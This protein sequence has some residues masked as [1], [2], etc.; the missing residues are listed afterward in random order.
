MVIYL[1]RGADLHMSQLMPLPLTVSVK[2]RLVLPF[3]YWLTRVVLEK[4]LLNGCVCVLLVIF[5]LNMTVLSTAAPNM[6]RGT[7]QNMNATIPDREPRKTAEPVEMLF[8]TLALG[9]QGI[10]C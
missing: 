7:C 9:A 3:W 1:E 2:S 5:V 10:T 6:N 8:R 4:G